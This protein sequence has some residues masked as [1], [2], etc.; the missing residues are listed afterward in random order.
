MAHLVKLSQLHASTDS[1][2]GGSVFGRTTK[3]FGKSSNTPR[4]R[5]P[6]RTLSVREAQRR[7]FL[8]WHCVSRAGGSS[9]PSKR[10]QAKT[11]WKRP[12]CEEPRGLRGFRQICRYALHEN[13][14]EE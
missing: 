5:F 1:P 13:G 7:T 8:G 6:S 9:N 2:V 14:F 10:R 11:V 4:T 3:F 12:T